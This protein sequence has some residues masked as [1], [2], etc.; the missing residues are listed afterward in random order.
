LARKIEM[1][2]KA[3]RSEKPFTGGC[4]CGAIRYE[5]TAEPVAMFRCYCR[6]CQRASSDAGNYVVI[7]P[8]ISFKFTRGPAL[9]FHSERRHRTTSEAFAPRVR[10]TVDGRRKPRGH[11]SHRW[12]QRR[13]SDDPVVSSAIPHLHVRCATVGLHEPALQKFDKYPPES[14]EPKERKST[15]LPHKPEDCRACSRS[16][17]IPAISTQL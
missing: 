7:V 3:N 17:S 9:P 11:I 15:V 6:D 14:E 2:E 16:T 13:R 4:V 5:C 1:K 8:A 10:L 12:H